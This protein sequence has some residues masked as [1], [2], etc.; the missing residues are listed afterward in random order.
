MTTETIQKLEQASAGLLMMSESDYPFKAVLWKGAGF[1]LT[2]A[3]LCFT[4]VANAGRL[5]SAFG[6]AGKIA[7][8]GI[9]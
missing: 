2:P 5:G 7:N 3:K 1:D 6:I 9:I 4:A 8:Q